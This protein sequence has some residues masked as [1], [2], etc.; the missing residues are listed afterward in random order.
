MNSF[1]K[2]LRGIAQQIVE[3]FHNSPDMCMVVALPYEYYANTNS[4]RAVYRRVVK[5]SGYN[6]ATR[7][8]NGD[9]YLIKIQNPDWT[10]K[11]HRQKV[12][13]LHKPFSQQRV[14]DL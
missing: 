2:K 3:D 7:I 10:A 9:L 6:I 12:L 1:Y 4:A 11:K 8:I 5:T 14:L 13:C